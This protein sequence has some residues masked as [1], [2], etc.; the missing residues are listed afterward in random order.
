VLAQIVFGSLTLFMLAP[1]VMQIGHL[2][3]ADA[4]WIS[5]VLMAA[6]F[7]SRRDQVSPDE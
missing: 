1:I 6:N 4:I 7:L 2:L 5:Y 3:L